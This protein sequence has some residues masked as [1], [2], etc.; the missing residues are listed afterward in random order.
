MIRR[1]ETNDFLTVP[2]LLVLTVSLVIKIFSKLATRPHI[3][4][5]IFSAQDLVEK[6]GKLLFFGSLYCMPF[7]DYAQGMPQMMDD[8]CFLY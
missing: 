8:K 7:E 5:G 1:I 3:P 6:K 2:S 4:N